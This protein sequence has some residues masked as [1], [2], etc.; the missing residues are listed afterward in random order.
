M[1]H[2]RGIVAV[3]GSLL[4]AA[5]T[6]AQAADFRLPRTIAWTSYNVGKSAYNQ[7][8]AIGSAPKN[9]AGVNLRVVPGKNDVSRQL[10]VGWAAHSC[11]SAGWC[12]RFREALWS[13]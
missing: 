10:P 8:V 3:A 1:Y 5:A 12:S 4:V 9:E 6:T 13:G 2:N 7:A 11:A